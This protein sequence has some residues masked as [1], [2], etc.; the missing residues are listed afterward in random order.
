MVTIVTDVQL[1]EGAEQ[2]WDEQMR[3]RMDAAKSQGGW[4]GGQLLRPDAQPSKRVI[5]GTWRSREDWRRWH[6]DS[7][8]TGTRENLDRL[9]TTPE[10]HCWHE[11]V[12][13][14]RPAKAI[15]SV[16]KRQAKPPRA[17]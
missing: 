12:L 8:F 1:K 6:E 11:V 7:R 5:V 15:E 4:I 16:R 2:Q 14:V 17:T 13:D 3:E 10:E 9:A